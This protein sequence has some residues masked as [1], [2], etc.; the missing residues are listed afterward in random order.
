MEK[1]MTDMFKVTGDLYHSQAWLLP[2][3][4]KVEVNK[5]TSVF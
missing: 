4:T 1:L 5:N 3:L 2:G